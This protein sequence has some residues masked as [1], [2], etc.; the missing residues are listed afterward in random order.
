MNEKLIFIEIICVFSLLLLSKKLFGKAGLF[1]WISSAVIIANM[2]TVKNACIFG[3][4]TAIGSVVFA[5]TFLAT[6]IL[7]EC[8]GVK[9]ARRGVYIGIFG[10]VMFMICSQ[11]AIHYI[12]SVIDYADEAMT[13]LFSMNLRISLSSVIM[14]FIA[15]IADVFIYEKIKIKT[16]GKKIW[17]R[18]NVAT[19]TCNCLENFFF[20]LFGFYGMFDFNQCMHVAFSIS[21]IETIIGLCD[22]PFLYLAVGGD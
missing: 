11:I 2:I 1:A 4:N 9:E 15:N 17:L 19:I 12:P 8:Y 3:M 22:T 18:N 13:K 20:V 5:S 21:V 14:C 7:T 16:H 6:D 10:A